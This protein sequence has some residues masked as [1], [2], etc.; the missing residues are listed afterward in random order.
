MPVSEER[1]SRKELRQ[2]AQSV[3]GKRESKKKPSRRR[4]LQWGILVAA[5]AVFVFSGIQLLNISGEY[6]EAEKEYQGLEQLAPLPQDEAGPED[7]QVDF[8]ALAQKNSEIVG[9]IYIPDSKVD[10]PMVKG[11]DNSFYVSHT[12][13][14]KAN[15]AGAIFLDWKNSGDFS[16]RNTVIYGHHMKNGSMFAALVEYKNPDYFNSHR[17]IYLYTPQGVYTATVFSAYVDV[18]TGPQTTISF[19][20]DAEFLSFVETMRNQSIT[21]ADTP[22]GAEDRIIT[23]S[24][25][26]YEYD[27]ARFIVQAVLHPVNTAE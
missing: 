13:E 11:T 4:I 25:C 26:T 16:D 6:G 23:L 2:A 14:K 18:A 22:I 19:A 8:A 27:D 10:Y 17:T 12:F 21:R 3:T 7:R 1:K 15:G 9:W 24:T 5:L 20:N